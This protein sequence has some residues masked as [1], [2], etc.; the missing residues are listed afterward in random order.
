MN[1]AQTSIVICASSLMLPHKFIKQVIDSLKSK[2]QVKQGC[3]SFKKRSL[4]QWHRG[5]DELLHSSAGMKVALKLSLKGEGNE[6][7]LATDE[8]VDIKPELGAKLIAQLKCIYSNAGSM[9]NE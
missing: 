3:N 4:N 1:N 6:M 7:R 8:P 5:R 9:G 2:N